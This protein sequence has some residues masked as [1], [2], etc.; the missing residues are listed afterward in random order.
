MLMSKTRWPAKLR[1]LRKRLELTQAQAAE[2][3][4]VAT[5]TW[6][7]WENAQRTPGRLALRLLKTA[8]PDQF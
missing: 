1:A 6:I 5:R 4:G 2:R 7:A 8:F 3:T